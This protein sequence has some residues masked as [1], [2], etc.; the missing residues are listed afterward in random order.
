[1]TPLTPSK[2]KRK[3]EMRKTP[4]VV[5]WV[6][7]NRSGEHLVQRGRTHQKDHDE[8]GAETDAEDHV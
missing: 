3:R 4:K 2:L 1:M 5:D 7:Q 6:R 8:D